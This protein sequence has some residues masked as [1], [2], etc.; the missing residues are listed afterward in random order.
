MRNNWFPA[1]KGAVLA[2]LFFFVFPFFAAPA[3]QRAVIVGRVLDDE[4]GQE[5]PCTVTIQTSDRKIVFDNP[6]STDGFRSA[7]HF[8]KDVPPGETVVTVSQGF[9]YEAS[10]QKIDL[11]P[12]QRVS[13][14]FRLRTQASLRHFGWYCGDNHVHMIHGPEKPGFALNFQYLALAARA[15]GLDYMSAAQN[16][17]LSPSETTPARLSELCR[18]ASTADFILAWNMEEPKNYWRGN[19]THCLGHCWFLGMHGYT[20]DGQDAIQLLLQM[21]ALDYQSEKT[22]TP[23][24]ESQALIHALGGVVAYTHPCRWWWGKWGGKGIYPVEAGKFVSNL[25]QELPYDTVVGPTYDAMDILMQS[26]DHD[27]SLEAQ[28]L[29][30]LLLNKG[31]RMPA[32]ASTDSDFGGRASA[33]PGVARVY[34]KVEGSPS[35]EAIAAAMKAG[36]NFVTTGPLLLM[37][38]GGHSVGDVIHLSGPSDFPVQLMAW[39]SGVL[40]ERVT[41]VELIRN[42]DTVKQF[43]VNAGRKEFRAE[44]SI[45][46]TGTAWYIAR[47]FG[48]NDLQVAITNPIYFEGSDFRSPPPTEAHVTGV[49]TDAG[50]K[51]LNGECDVIRMVGL[52]PVR[53]SRHQFQGGQFTVDIPG[54]ARLRVEVTGYKPMMKSVFVDYAPLLRMTLNLR[55]AELTDWRTYDEIKSLLRDVKLE[56]SLA[57]AN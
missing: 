23:N 49:V 25:A 3:E 50:G 36:K 4:S 17:N 42:G 13:L 54:T 27:A 5:I 29:W 7:G 32:T 9:D 11:Q 51:P 6:G 22:P 18:S 40:G 35:V 46:E 21:S 31:Y 57:R 33:N 52:G 43:A 34:T 8:Q 26:W 19:V 48:S 30:F 14:V 15:A 38:I 1:V 39:P 55:E 10:Q 47:C 2:V 37:E 20:P 12:G 24:F 16:W 53:L 44:F 28:R 56:F 45:H 41:K